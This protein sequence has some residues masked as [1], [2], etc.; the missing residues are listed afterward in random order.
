[1]A[2]DKNYYLD[3]KNKLIGRYVDKMSSTIDKITATLNEFFKDKEQLAAEQAEID[4]IITDTK[5]EKKK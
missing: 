4:K 5:E 2:Y 3:K 1:M